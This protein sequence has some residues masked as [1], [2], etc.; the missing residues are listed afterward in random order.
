MCF[1]LQTLEEEKETHH[2]GLNPLKRTTLNKSYQ[3]SGKVCAVV[4]DIKLI[5]KTGTL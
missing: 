2:V 3:L 4:D 1:F 5:I